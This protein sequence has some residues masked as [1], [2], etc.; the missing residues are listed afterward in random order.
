M[1]LVNLKIKYKI[2]KIFK[3]K[4]N[5]NLGCVGVDVFLQF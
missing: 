3:F 2:E 5:K 4:R 1:L